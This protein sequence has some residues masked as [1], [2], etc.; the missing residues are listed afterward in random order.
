MKLSEICVER[1]VFAWVMTLVLVLVGIVSVYRIPLQQ[2]PRIERPY[3]T[4]ETSI[5][6]AGPEIVEAQVT[7]II[8]DA[9]AGIEGIENVTSISSTED[10][11][12]TIEFSPD[13]NV[14]AAIN[15][16]RDKLSKSR[17]KLPE[18]TSEPVLVRSRAEEKPI[19][20]IA[21]TSQTI[22]PNELYDFAIREIQKELES[23]KGVARVD[24]LGA[25]QYEM[26]IFLDP[27]R[28]TAHG[29]TVSEVMS[30]IKKQNIEKPAGKIIGKDREYLVTTVASLEKPEEFENLVILTKKGHSIRIRDIGY[31][32][33]TS[34]DKKTK[35][36]YNGKQGVSIS[37]VKQSI[38]NPIDVARK[39][40]KEIDKIAKNLP[41]EM[42]IHVGSD[43]TLFIEQSLKEVYK[44]IFEATILVILVVFLFIRSFTASLVPLVTIPVSLIGTFFFMYLLNF[45]INMFTLMSMVLAIGL[46]VD[47]AI[48]ILE[49]I[50]R[51]IEDGLEPFKATFKSIKEISFAIIAMT[52][53]LAAVYTPVSLAQ[54]L[55]GKLLTEFSVTLAVS[56]IISGFA[57]LTLSPMMCARMLKPRKDEKNSILH[58]FFER[59]FPLEKWIS[60]LEKYYERTLK[61]FLINRIYVVAFCAGFAVFGYALYRFL[62]SE[63]TPKEDQGIIT[64]EGQAPQSATL[65]YTEEHVYK[66]DDIVG[67]IKE[68]DRRVTQIINPTFDMSIHLTKDRKRSTDDVVQELRSKMSNITGIEARINS[69]SSSVSGDDN[70]AVQFVVR[71]NKTYR[72]LK[73]IAHNVTAYLY[74]SGMV[75]AVLTEVRGDTQDFIVTILRDKLASLNIEPAVVADTIDSLIRGKKV[76]TFKKENKLYDVRLSVED[77]FRRTPDDINNLF[78]RSNDKEAKLIHLSDIV[79]IHSKAGPIEIHRHNRMRSIAISALLKPDFSL[80]DAIDKINNTIAKEA[81]PSDAR[82]NFIG[83][84]KRY[85]T[86]SK[87]ILLVFGLAIAFIY[88]VMAAQFESWSDPLIII[89]SVPLSLVGGVLALTLI[90]NGSLNLYSNIGFITL[91]GLITKHGILIVDFANKLCSKGSNA[92]DAVISASKLRLRPILMTT[93]AMVLGAAPLAFATG[94]SSESRRQLG[95]VI[96]G[97]MLVG[98]LLTLFVIPIFYAYLASF[99]R[100]ALDRKFAKS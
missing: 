34:N 16:I 96:V 75:N 62:P 28:L 27:M 24:V 64:V 53:T 59:Y 35:T 83:D 7:R 69:S 39:V 3:V 82:L 4:I 100:Q 95:C 86:E 74:A 6:G 5:P 54:G 55:T 94:A 49:N 13:R 26:N 89:M 43:K 18:E 70:Q 79:N 66:A 88:L 78:L 32:K 84:T 72:E 31:V 37:V 71:G 38:A 63:L 58:V 52:L 9:V 90:N 33:I 22:S 41:E 42:S 21:L 17:D 20:S 47:D 45:S 92:I 81:M 93:L 19:M 30:A 10:S 15:D 40:K 76:N 57:A 29:L 23:I 91:I 97:G 61:Y 98:T 48:V 36:R 12:V 8:E 51:H 77:K 44:T 65:E 50:H 80:G 87:T 73:D 85:L 60:E 67:T 99:K 46:V 14:D 2:Y 25:G 68:V 11:K 1:P 56:V